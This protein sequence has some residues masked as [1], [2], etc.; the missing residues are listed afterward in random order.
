MIGG[1]LIYGN[2]IKVFGKHKGS[3]QMLMTKKS[4]DKYPKTV[5]NNP[6]SAKFTHSRAFCCNRT[7]NP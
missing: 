7:E 6:E 3:C 2:V 5:K 4:L 1:V